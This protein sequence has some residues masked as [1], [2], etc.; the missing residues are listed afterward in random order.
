[1]KR[2]RTGLVAWAIAFAV[3]AQPAGGTSADGPQAHASKT[4]KPVPT[5]NGGRATFINV[6]GSLGCRAA[7]RVA[8]RANGRR[9]KAL[10]FDC[11]PGRKR[12]GFGRLYGCGGTLNGKTSGV[13][14]FYKKVAASGA[15]PHTSA[16]R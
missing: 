2:F 6:S 13:G 1:M 3:L 5:R 4:C 11:K 8:A 12:S 9:Y 14:F 10:G 7:R 16:A 15:G